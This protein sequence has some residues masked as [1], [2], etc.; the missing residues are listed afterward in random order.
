VIVG[1]GVAS[2]IIGEVGAAIILIMVDERVGKHRKLK[3]FTPEN[4]PVLCMLD[5][6]ESAFG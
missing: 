1:V 3:I 2:A 5:S 4:L 6:D